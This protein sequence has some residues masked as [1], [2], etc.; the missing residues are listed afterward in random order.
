MLQRWLL[1]CRGSQPETPCRRSVCDVPCWPAELSIQLP[2]ASETRA[3]TACPVRSTHPLD[4]CTEL[5]ID[6]AFKPAEGGA[7]GGASP[8]FETS[9]QAPPAKIQRPAF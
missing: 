2:H 4:D 1:R 6:H 5:A 3:G 8:P 9:S 7:S